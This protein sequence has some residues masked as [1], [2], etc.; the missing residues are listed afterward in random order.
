MCVCVCEVARAGEHNIIDQGKHTKKG[1]GR[2]ET[3][4][5]RETERTKKAGEKGA[6]RADETQIGYPMASANRDE[7]CMKLVICVLFQL[8]CKNTFTSGARGRDARHVHS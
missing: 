5:K 8:G 3:M 2:R 7:L 4:N 1:C 6:R